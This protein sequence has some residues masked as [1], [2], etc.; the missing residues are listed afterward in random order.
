MLR[1]L[2]WRC[3]AS[4]FLGLGALGVVLPGLPTTPFLLV[5][6]WAGARGWPALEARLLAHPRYGGMIRDWRERRAV[7]RR[8]KWLASAMMLTSASLLW[9]TPTALMLRLG[10]TALLLCVALWLW[11]RPQ[12]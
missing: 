9:L 7:P 3:L 2:L 4:V 1:Q 10:V 5:A 8:A 12:A 6:A 11:T